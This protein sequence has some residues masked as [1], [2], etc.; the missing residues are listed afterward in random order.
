VITALCALFI[1]VT[2]S[3]I[4]GVPAPHVFARALIFSVVFFGLG[5]GLRFMINSYFPELFY[6]DDQ[7]LPPDIN[8]TTGA[9][10]NITLDTIGEYAVP[11]LY[12]DGDS[13]ELGN[14]EDLISGVFKPRVAEDPEMAGGGQQAFAPVISEGGIDQDQESGYNDREDTFGVSDFED[15]AFQEGGSFQKEAVSEKPRVEKPV[16]TPSFGDDDEGLGGL[17]D[18]D[19]MATAFSPTFGGDSGF[20]AASAPAP[21]IVPVENDS[22][23]SKYNTGNKPQPMDRDYDAKSLA[24]GIRTVLSKS[25]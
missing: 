20:G 12:R 19:T 3:V 23:S 22:G 5:F 16:F 9:Q 17:P 8:E 6:P 4:A 25:D 2:L 24:E 15:V 21:S 14:I 7:I 10:V 1:S 13:G 11:E 18:L